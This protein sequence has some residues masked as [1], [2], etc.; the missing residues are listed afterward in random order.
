MKVYHGE[1]ADNCRKGF[2]VAY[3]AKDHRFI[4]KFD[5]NAM[6]GIGIY[7]HPNGDRFEGIFINNKP[8]GKGSFYKSK[9]IAENDDKIKEGTNSSSP[10]KSR[11]SSFRRKT[12]AHSDDIH[13]MWQAGKPTTQLLEEPFKPQVHDMP[14]RTTSFV[15]K[16][17][18]SS[19]YLVSISSHLLSL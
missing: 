3:L 4:G 5:A 2:G 19:L 9:L 10:S 12:Y 11:S 13:C 7:S 6:S 17:G 8:Y 15:A 18:D 1:F 16:V 14:S